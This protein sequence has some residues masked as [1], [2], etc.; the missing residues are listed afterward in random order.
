MSFT[1]D[2]LTVAPSKNTNAFRKIIQ[3]GQVKLDDDCTKLPANKHYLWG[4]VN[5]E[6][7]IF[8]KF[9]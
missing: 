3:F 2:S 5:W 1:A 6:A 9:I 7:R 8:P 4:D